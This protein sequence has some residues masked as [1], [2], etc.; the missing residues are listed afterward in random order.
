MSY[1][2]GVKAGLASPKSSMRASG[3]KSITILDGLS[4]WASTKRR[5]HM[6]LKEEANGLPD[7]WV[8]GEQMDFQYGDRI[9]QMSSPMCEGGDCYE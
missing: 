4:E 3:C 7:T 9:R 2:Y 1:Y 5:P 6:K 8:K